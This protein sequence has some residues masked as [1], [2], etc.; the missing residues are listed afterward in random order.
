M[1]LLPKELKG[2][3]VRF[4]RPDG[5]KRDYRV[6]G[7]GEQVHEAVDMAEGKR[8]SVGKYLQEQ[9]GHQLKYSKGFTLQGSL[10]GL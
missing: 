4:H 6:N 9:Y 3:K 5:A 2:L 1:S 10:R 7:F 8:M